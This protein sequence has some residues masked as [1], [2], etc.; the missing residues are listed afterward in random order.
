MIKDIN[1]NLKSQEEQTLFLFFFNVCSSYRALER[2]IVI[3]FGISK[4]D[5]HFKPLLV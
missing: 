1:K 2:E 4:F 5:G 3:L